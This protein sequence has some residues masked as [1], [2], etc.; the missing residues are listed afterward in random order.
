MVT[1]YDERN[2]LYQTTLEKWGESRGDCSKRHFGQDEHE[3]RGFGRGKGKEDKVRCMICGRLL[4]VIDWCHLRT[5]GVSFKEYKKLFPNSKTI[6]EDYRRK[7]SE[8]RTGKT[9]EE[10]YGEEEAENMKRQCSE[11]CKKLWREG[12]MDNRGGHP[13]HRRELTYEEEYG[14]ERA[15]KIKLKQANS[16]PRFRGEKNP[17][18]GRITYPKP[19]FV[20]GL[21]HLVRSSLEERVFLIFKRLGVKYRYEPT[22][23]VFFRKD[24][25]K[26]SYM[27]DAILNDGTIIEVKGY[28]FEKF[29]RR[30]IDFKEQYSE[31]HIVLIT[32]EE[33]KVSQIPQNICE[34]K[35]VEE[36]EDWFS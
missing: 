32:E 22:R 8:W 20:E 12:V 35:L 4:K 19:R 14:E 13:S 16:A 1:S 27:P 33:R 15:K 3:T 10:I 25:R 18:F 26:A 23:F 2:N 9:Y 29:V 17:S 30:M 24:G 34:I 31:H 6:S 5:H 28:A 7:L 11:H 21:G 36:L